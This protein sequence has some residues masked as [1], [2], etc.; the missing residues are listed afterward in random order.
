[1]GSSIENSF[2]GMLGVIQTELR[3]RAVHRGMELADIIRESEAPNCDKMS[4]RES[5]DG[6]PAVGRS[7]WKRAVTMVVRRWKTFPLIIQDAVIFTGF[8]SVILAIAIGSLGRVAHVRAVRSFGPQ[9]RLVYAS[10]NTVW[11][12][13]FRH[14]FLLPGDDV[15]YQHMEGPQIYNEVC[16]S[17]LGNAI[18]QTA[19]AACDGKSG[20][21]LRKIGIDVC[22][23]E[24]TSNGASMP[25]IRVA[26]PFEHTS[27]PLGSSS[28]K[29]S[30]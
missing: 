19:D 14:A 15:R 9:Y 23:L 30:N 11:V 4:G 18:P 7:S 12:V 16:N 2:P 13:G 1:M 8:I 21:A 26:A 20:T 28:E 17:V 25:A 5:P 3:E 6:A 29:T 10:D 22:T 24:D 27:C